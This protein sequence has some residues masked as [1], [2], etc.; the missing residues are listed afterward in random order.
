MVTVLPLCSLLVRFFIS[1]CAHF[2]EHN[3]KF[4]FWKSVKQTSHL[5]IFIYH[6]L[7]SYFSDLRKNTYTLQAM[8][9]ETFND[10]WSKQR[11]SLCRGFSFAS[12][13]MVGLKVRP[14]SKTDAFHRCQLSVFMIGVWVTP[15]INT[16]ESL[17][18]FISYY[19]R[20]LLSGDRCTR[21]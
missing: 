18:F 13:S 17:N 4:T 7:R 3:V 9:A 15:I 6:S 1:G 16:D 8:Y 19:H 5:G 2:F 14:M 20:V 12:V 11:A 10:F 21:W